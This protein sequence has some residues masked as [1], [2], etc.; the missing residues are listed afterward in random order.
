MGK[1]CTQ[2]SYGQPCMD[3]EHRTQIHSPPHFMSC[4]SAC[5]S[6]H[7]RVQACMQACTRLTYHVCTWL[8]GEL[9]ETDHRDGPG[10]RHEAA[11]CNPQHVPGQDGSQWDPTQRGRKLR[12]DASHISSERRCPAQEHRWR[13]DQ[14]LPAGGF[15]ERQRYVF[16]KGKTRGVTPVSYRLQLSSLG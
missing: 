2:H 8:A 5:T 10:H 15:L 16:L 12:R 13:P 9:A 11:L 14:P 1:V 3:S 6:L 4:C 7:T